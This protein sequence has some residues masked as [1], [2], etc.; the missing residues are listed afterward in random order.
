MRYY[1]DTNTLTFILNKDKDNIHYDIKGILN[2]YANTLLA[3][4][5]TVQELLFLFRIGKIKLK[6]KNEDAI[7]SA[8][9][10]FGIKTVFFNEN[11]FKKYAKL[12]IANSHKDINDHLIIA[13]SISDKVPLI[14]SDSKFKEYVSQ[15]LNFI[16]NK[17]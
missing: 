9:E 10:E 8:I 1:L 12:Q 4:S 11:H 16:Y 17:R 5:V 2:D 14:S 3:S 13:Q 6:N 15:G 7:L